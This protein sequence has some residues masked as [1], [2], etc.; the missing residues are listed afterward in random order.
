MTKPLQ[1][2]GIGHALVDIIASCEE[3]LLG[4]FSLAK[5]TM[6]LTS[7][8]E[9][10]ALYDKMGPAV[11]TSGGSAANT[12][13]GIASLGG[14]VG[15]MG[16]VGRDQ[17]AEVFAHDISS[18]GVR[19]NHGAAKSETP[20][21]RCLILVTPDGE[22]TMNT[23]LGAAA[24]FAGSDLDRAAID[25]SEILY[26]EG[27][28]FDP[29]AARASFHTAADFARVNSTKVA[30]TLSD[31]FCV[32]RHREGFRS[33]IRERVDIVFANEKE[34]LSLFPGASFE[35]ACAA[36][37]A[38][39][40]IAVITRSEKGSVILNGERA[41][42]VPAVPVEKLVD[43]TGAGDLYAAGF[44]FALASGRDLK[45]CGQLGSLA[46][47]EVISHVGPRPLHPLADLARSHGL[48]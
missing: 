47:S 6:R 8:D 26:L 23:N 2:T 40:P 24:E 27:Y 13:A 29:V 38:E 20:T 32:D 48:L 12:C 44:L 30:F 19:F 25:G 4:Q 21:G 16:R 41:I 46:A 33:F 45:T 15:F 17:F 1:V 9:A 28:L 5:G 7:P 42:S 22:R 11:E 34:L 37:K 31:P 43:A 14:R 3:E 18:I 10:A 35:E 36:I 39:C